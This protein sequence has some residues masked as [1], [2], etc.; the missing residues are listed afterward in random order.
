[1]TATSC[2]NAPWT[3][4]E[5]NNINDFQRSNWFHGFTCPSLAHTSHVDLI[6][7]N[8]A[9]HCSDPHCD[10]TQTWVH[11]FMASG[12]W[13]NRSPLKGFGPTQGE[14]S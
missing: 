8:D 11:E 12:E 13:R 2:S 10:Y 5:V 7:G 3:D 4:Q 6:A 14:P 1:M 9:L